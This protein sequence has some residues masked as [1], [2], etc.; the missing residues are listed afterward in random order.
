MHH[1]EQPNFV[2]GR[3]CLD[4]ANT[5]AIHDGLSPYD[6]IAR[7]AQLISWLAKA[8]VLRRAQADTFAREAEAHAGE[9][10]AA[11]R[12]ARRLRDSCYRIFSA[13]GRGA[14]PPRDEIE[15]LNQ[16]LSRA[17]CGTR[18]RQR[19]SSFGWSWPEGSR[20]ADAATWSIARS[21]AE[22]LVSHELSRVNEC[23]SS[24]CAWLFLDTTKNRSRKFC[25]SSGCGNRTRVRRHYERMRA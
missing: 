20:L 3:L 11:V 15:Y 1:N 17:T 7:P 24:T 12:S 2:G 9:A 16:I 5:V 13:I 14:P 10:G 21:A 19:G 23:R 4:F 25:T 18:I 6:H 8:G 22:L